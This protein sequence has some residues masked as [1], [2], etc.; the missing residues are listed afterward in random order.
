[1]QD[2]YK[3]P[4]L[5]SVKPLLVFFLF[6]LISSVVLAKQYTQD[7]NNPITY[8]GGDLRWCKLYGVCTLDTLIVYNISVIGDV[9]NVTM[10]LVT[11]NITESFNVGGNLEAENITALDKFKGDGSLLTSLNAE[12][13]DINLPTNCPSANA[14]YGFGD[15]MSTTLCRDS[16]VNIDGDTMTGQLNIDN[17]LNVTGDLIVNNSVFFVNSTNE[18]IGIGTTNPQAKLHILQSGTA[19]TPVIS[20]DTVL[21]I[22]NDEASW[23]RLSIIGNGFGFSQIYFGDTDD[24]DVGGIW[25]GHTTNAFDFVIAAN[26]WSSF[27]ITSTSAVVNEDSQDD[28]D[29]KVESDNEVNMLFVDS[30]DDLVK[31]AGGYGSTGAT[32][33]DNGNASFDGNIIAENVFLPQ[34]IFSHTNATIP[35]LGAST[36]TNITFSQEDTD[37]KQGISHTYNDETNHTFTIMEDGIYNMDYDLDIEDDSGTPTTIDVAGRLILADGTEVLGSV[38]ET[39]VTKQGTEAELSHNFLVACNAGDVL[40]FQFIADDADVR[41]STHGTFGD[42]PE[43]AT[44]LMNKIANLP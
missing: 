40:V 36:W 35:V 16:W 1:M 19:G 20:D 38:F 3:K 5:Q 30:G 37:V 28:I 32:I 13:I 39:D 7:Y 33:Y 21:V 26:P 4:I 42:H 22:Q 43:S 25:Y 31:F 29:F 9:F 12:N 8:S 17:I 44:I 10:N 24:E 27:R 23:T 2:W 14:M 15:N 6:I 18:S 11:W 34:Y 41:I